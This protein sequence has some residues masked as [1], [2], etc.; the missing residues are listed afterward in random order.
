MI[1]FKHPLKGKKRYLLSIIDKIVPSESGQSFK[2]EIL[3]H[4]P[5]KE[6]VREWSEL[7]ILL[8]MPASLK[9]KLHHLTLLITE[10]EVP[11]TKHTHKRKK[12]K[13]I[14]LSKDRQFS[15]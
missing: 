10:Y 11:S 15:N 3:W 12:N 5:D 4:S 14:S 8:I 9:H 2:N 6:H 1:W 13:N 7:A